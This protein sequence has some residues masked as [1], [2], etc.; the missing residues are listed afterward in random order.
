[1]ESKMETPTGLGFRV[2]RWDNGK[3]NGNYYR[4]LG[5]YIYMV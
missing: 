3:Q 4:I 1:M 2:I 5:L